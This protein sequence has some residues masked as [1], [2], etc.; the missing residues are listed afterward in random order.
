MKTG[1]AGTGDGFFDRFR[2]TS[3]DRFGIHYFT[4][5]MD[6]KA[7]FSEF[8]RYDRGGLKLRPTE[9]RALMNTAPG[10][11]HFG[12]VTVKCICHLDVSFQ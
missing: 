4:A 2:I 1:L 9:L 7:E 8:L 10:F 3:E 6:F 5:E 11:D 12:Y